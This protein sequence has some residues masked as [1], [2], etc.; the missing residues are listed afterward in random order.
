MFIVL[1]TKTFFLY[2]N[3]QLGLKQ[4]GAQID[5]NNQLKLKLTSHYKILVLNF[6]TELEC[7][8]N[9]KIFRVYLKHILV[10]K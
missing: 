9:E 6:I 8:E 7:F 3:T 10:K 5:Q 4:N 2:F 1:Q